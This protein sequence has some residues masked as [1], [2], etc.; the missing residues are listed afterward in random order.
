MFSRF[1]SCGFI[2]ELQHMSTSPE[3]ED[4]DFVAELRSCLQ[5]M[6]DH[7]EEPLLTLFNGGRARRYILSPNGWVLSETSP[8]PT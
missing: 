7:S 3:Q 8:D 4:D 5:C 2:S 1:Y 6:Y